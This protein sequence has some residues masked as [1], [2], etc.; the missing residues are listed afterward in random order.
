M[1]RKDESKPVFSMIML[2]LKEPYQMITLDGNIELEPANCVDLF[3]EVM[4]SL[5]DHRRRA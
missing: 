1:A 3:S 5:L 2:K 4:F